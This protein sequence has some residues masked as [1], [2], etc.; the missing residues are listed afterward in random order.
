VSLPTRRSIFS[1]R[2]SIAERMPSS[3][4]F[5]A[6]ST[7]TSVARIAMTELCC[8]EPLRNATLGEWEL[9]T[10]YTVTGSR[11]LTIDVDQ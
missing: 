7:T 1:S 11:L 9:Q 4:V 10:D 2:R 6:M 5:L 8:C 3:R